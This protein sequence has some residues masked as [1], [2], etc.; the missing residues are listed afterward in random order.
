[1]EATLLVTP[2]QLE[3]AASDFS[4]Q[5]T[6]VQSLHE[7]MLTK[8]R[9]LSNSWTGEA[10]SAYLQKFNALE[11]SMNVIFNMIQ[12]HVKDLNTIAQQF[13]SAESQAA[14]AANELPASTLS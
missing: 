7:S 13:K 3:T 1:M 12:E 2:E 6:Q 5:A 9:N 14:S 4:A 11:A 8:V 10:S